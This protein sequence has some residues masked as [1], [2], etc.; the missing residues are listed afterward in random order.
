MARRLVFVFIQIVSAA[1]RKAALSHSRPMSGVVLSAMLRA[2][3]NSSQVV[4]L[5]PDFR[6]CGNWYSTCCS[7]ATSA[8]DADDTELSPSEM[9]FEGTPMTL[10]QVL[11]VR[12]MHH[13]WVTLAV[14]PFETDAIEAGIDREM[15]VNG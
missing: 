2:N 13:L 15:A 1:T 11:A 3:L 8:I 6:W 12:A 14:M 4:A 7:P 10:L 9:R 5:T